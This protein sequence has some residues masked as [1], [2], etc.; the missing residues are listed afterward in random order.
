MPPAYTAAQKAAIQQVVSFTNSDRTTAA[1]ILR[2]HNWNAEQ[3]INGYFNQS[4]SATNKALETN[5]NRIFDTY[6]DNPAEKETIGVDG[7]MQYL[8]ALSVPLDDIA[9]LVVMELV[10]SPTMGEITRKGFVDG[11]STRQAD[12]LDKQ[13]T[14]VSQL[15]SSLTDPSSRSV[16]KRVY[17]HTFVI[18]RPPGQKAIPLEQAIEYWRLLFSANGLHWKTATTPWLEWWVEFLESKWRRTVNKDMWEQ[19]FNFA[20]KSVQDESLGFWSEDAAWPGVIDEFVEWVK[21]DKGRGAKVDGD[22][23]MEEY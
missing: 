3:A 20:E 4:G 2:N 14:T 8:E 12:T 13:R 9:A 21:T 18:A 6:L 5:L 11:W 17:K 16:L 1:R 23:D 19:L 15:R 7:T 22:E 10:Q